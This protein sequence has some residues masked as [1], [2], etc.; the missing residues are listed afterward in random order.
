MTVSDHRTARRAAHFDD[1]ERIAR[2]HTESWRRTYRGMMSDEFLDG[3]AFEN[4]RSVWH[5]RLGMPAAN[6]YVCIAQEGAEIIGF[7]CAFA[8]QDPVWGSYIDNLHV[9]YSRHRRGVGRALM[10]S[11]AEWLCRV[12]PDRGVYLWVMEANA[13]ARAFYECLGATDAGTIDLEDPGGGRALNCRYVWAR[14]DL[15][16]GV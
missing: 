8:D 14:P 15:L 3:G 11:A 10:R 16:L 9:V 13:A 6:Q 12:E 7:I 4:R 5:E 2:L 1:A